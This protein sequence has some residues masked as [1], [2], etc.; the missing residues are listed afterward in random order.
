[1]PGSRPQEGKNGKVALRVRSREHVE[2]VSEIVTVP[3]GIPTDV[4]VRLMVEAVAFTVTDPFFQT[5]T[6]AGLV[7]PCP[8]INGG[9]ITGDG[10][11]PQINQS[12]I[13]GFIQELGFKD[14]K[15]PLCR[16]K[17]L[18]GFYLE[19]RHKVINGYFFDRVCLFALLLWLFGLL[20]RRMK[21]IG[22]VVPIGQPQAPCKVVESPDS[23]RITDSKH[24][25][26]SVK[27]VL[28]QRGSPGSKGSDFELHGKQ[29]RSQHVR[30]KPRLR[31][32]QGIPVLHDLIYSGKIEVP[33][34]LH[35]FP[36]SGVKRSACIWIIL[37]KL[38]QNTVLVG[39]MSADINRFQNVHLQ[40]RLKFLLN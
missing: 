14:I 7:F 20:L 11:I 29:I 34:L 25:E 16:S 22:K 15:E 13:D 36:C 10:K 35:Y 33:E 27:I 38:S 26:D 30:R 39:G 3:V 9:A 18:R 23:R 8:G 19:F 24:G 40:S 5:I 21:R 4:A 6:G 2:V 37:T 17:I 31:T 28:L 12:F 32:E 1:M